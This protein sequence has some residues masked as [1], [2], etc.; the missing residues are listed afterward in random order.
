MLGT[1]LRD[2][3]SCSD[4]KKRAVSHAANGLQKWTTAEMRRYVLPCSFKNLKLEITSLS[5]RRRP[6][7]RDQST[8][9]SAASKEKTEMETWGRG[10]LGRSRIS[11][12]KWNEIERHE[13][14]EVRRPITAT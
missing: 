6:G 2:H 3:S 4:A 9:I 5:T 14:K 7:Y 10:R 11:T 8:D 1:R 12:Y 13:R